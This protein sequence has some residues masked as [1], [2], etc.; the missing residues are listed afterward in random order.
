MSYYKNTEIATKFKV[1]NS[2]VGEWVKG[3]RA[4]KNNLQIR[5]YRN[6]DRILIN[7]HNEAEM[8][9]LKEKGVKYKTQANMKKVMPNKKFYSTFTGQQIFDIISSIET[10]NEIPLQY[11]YLGEGASYWHSYV[12]KSFRE[13][14]D[15]NASN[16]VTNAEEM[17]KLAK[18]IILKELTQGY[19]LNIIDI[20]VGDARPVRFIIEELTK[21]DLIKSYVAI[22]I[23]PEL[24]EIAEENLKTWFGK[25]F[26]VISVVKNFN[27]DSIQDVVY[28]NL[29]DKNDDNVI[30]LI[31]F[32]GSTIENQRDIIRSL[33]N[34][35]DNLGK[36]DY[37]LLGNTL[38]NERAKVHFNIAC[39]TP[40]RDESVLP[41]LLGW[42]PESLGLGRDDYDVKVVYDEV[43]KA[44]S[45]NIFF[46]KA[47]EIEIEK[48]KIR[49]TLSF[50]RGDGLLLWRHRHHSTSEII[51]LLINL[52]FELFHYT[53]SQ[54][55]IQSMSML[56]V[57]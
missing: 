20:G 22:D 38:D 17:L 10:H 36:N 48:D 52:G 15:V 57:K 2:T 12:N 16:T 27:V 13:K 44:R 56:K 32:L 31:F 7:E 1:S 54:D 53:T 25:D 29:T 35:R 11:A 41:S 34:L 37:L 46:N 55:R 47:I 21:L 45:L 42:I 50:E 43:K 26:P 8:A 6:K 3:A 40:G 9:R 49:K 4:G 30:N 19:K 28:E 5:K 24:L 51:Q 14:E 33:L 39:G 18:D 23:S